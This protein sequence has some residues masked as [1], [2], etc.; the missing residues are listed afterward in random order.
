MEAARRRFWGRSLPADTWPTR[1][2]GGSDG[3]AGL[4]V[5]TPAAFRF[6]SFRPLA[7]P[8]PTGAACPVSQDLFETLDTSG[9]SPATAAAILGGP[10]TRRTVPNARRR[11]MRPTR[12]DGMSGVRAMHCCLARP[13]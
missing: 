1:R 12:G 8:T 6:A 3:G 2:A 11:H 7:L 4:R 5:L 13:T 9:T 10:L